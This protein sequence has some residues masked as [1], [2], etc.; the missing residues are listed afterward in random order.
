MIAVL[1]LVLSLSA[2]SCLAPPVAGPITRPYRAP[3]CA[4]C[5][6]HRGVEYATVP[7]TP[8]RAVQA[9]SVTFAGQVAGTIYVVVAQ[10][11]GLTATY[12]YLLAADVHRGSVVVAGQVV[13]RSSTRLYFGWRR[14]DVP[15]DPTP[16]LAR[17]HVSPRLVPA[18]GSRPRPVA[19]RMECRA[20]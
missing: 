1:A 17:S 13:G 7:G 11:D 5:V 3:A 9:G 15:V 19:G 12:G 6:G 10:P 16:W 2:P 8:V 20:G 14:G 4:Y 18:D